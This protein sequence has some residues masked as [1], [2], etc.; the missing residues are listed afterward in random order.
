MHQDMNSLYN[1][2]EQ[3]CNEFMAKL[4]KK[5]KEVSDEFKKLSP[6]NQQKVNDTIKQITG[7]QTLSQI[8]PIQ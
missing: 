4:F 5:G 1:R 6:E 3:E 8:F 7:L 2:E